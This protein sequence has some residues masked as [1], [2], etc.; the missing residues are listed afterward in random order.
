ML[1]P[2]R[3]HR[4]GGELLVRGHGELVATRCVAADSAQIL[5]ELKP[6]ILKFLPS[7][8]QTLCDGYVLQIQQVAGQLRALVYKA[9]CPQLIK[10]AA[11]SLTSVALHSAHSC[12]QIL[13]LIAECGW[14]SRKLREQSHEWV[15]RLV[16]NCSEVRRPTTSPPPPL[17][18]VQVWDYMMQTDQF[19]ESSS[20][21][22]EQVW[23]EVCQCAFDLLLEGYSRA[24][25]CSSEG[26]ASMTM[27][28]FALHEGLNNVHL[29]RPPRG[30]HH[31]DSYLRMSYLS[32]EEMM[33][34]VHDNWQSFAYRH[35]AGMLTQTLTSVLSSK[36]LKDALAVIDGLYELDMN[37]EGNVGGNKLSSLLSTRLREDNKLTKLISSKFSGR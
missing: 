11:V 34:F 6:K 2:Q 14:E 28:V 17:I 5:S 33:Q 26:R 22:R 10:Q 23:L 24:R 31:I 35:V 37:N 1:R 4:G 29:C 19:A 15:D 16:E 18:C 7:R 30:K 8:T 36:K 9:V 13:P 21:V 12:L 25:K 32:E 3:A 20:L 27:D